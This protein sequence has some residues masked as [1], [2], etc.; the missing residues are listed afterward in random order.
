MSLLDQDLG[1]CVKARRGAHTYILGAQVN[2]RDLVQ[3]LL[4]A[5]VEDVSYSLALDIAGLEGPDDTTG[6]VDPLAELFTAGGDS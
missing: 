4:E 1:G 3:G 6:L 2:S 5:P